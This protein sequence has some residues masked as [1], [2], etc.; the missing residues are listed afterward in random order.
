MH[1]LV[2]TAPTA[3]YQQQTPLNDILKKRLVRYFI[4]SAIATYIFGKQNYVPEC[5]NIYSLY[6]TLGVRQ[7]P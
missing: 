2:I 6:G 1:N 5:L 7:S 3:T 4:I